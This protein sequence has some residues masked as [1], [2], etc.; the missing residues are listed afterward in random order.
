MTLDPKHARK[1][2]AAMTPGPL[3]V[4]RGYLTC[5]DDGPERVV[6]STS[7]GDS[8]DGEQGYSVASF[9]NDENAGNDAAGICYLRNHADEMIGAVEELA[10]LRDRITVICDEAFGLQPVQPAD[11]SLT[12]IEQG[13]HRRRLLLHEL[14]AALYPVVGDDLPGDKA[15]A[16]DIRRLRR[17]ETA[18]REAHRLL[19]EWCDDDDVTMT[20]DSDVRAF[21]TLQSALEVKP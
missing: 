10:D 8:E 11:D 15:M 4:E 13:L 2:V 6:L 19:A 21:R 5:C 9:G 14:H 1:L 17:I 18:A 3:R 7:D 12:M 16:E 20:D